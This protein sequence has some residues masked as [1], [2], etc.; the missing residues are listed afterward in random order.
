MYVSLGIRKRIFSLSA[1]GCIIYWKY[2]TVSR[3]Q[4]IFGISSENN[5]KKYGEGRA[6]RSEEIGQPLWVVKSPS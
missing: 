4:S 1:K 2:A 5:N 6:E 3:F